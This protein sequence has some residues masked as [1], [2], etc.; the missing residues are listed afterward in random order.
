MCSAHRLAVAAGVLCRRRIVPSSLRF[1]LVMLSALVASRA[2]LGASGSNT[3]YSG[4]TSGSWPVDSSWGSGILNII[5]PGATSGTTN[6]DTATFDSGSI[7][8][9]IT[10]DANRNLENITFDTSAAAYTIGT[11]GGNA[12]LTTSFGTI[13]IASTFSGSNLNET[14]NAP[15]TLEGDYTLADNSAHTGV[16]LDFGGAISA[17]DK[18]GGGSVLTVAGA[19]NTAI[20][21]AIGGIKTID[22]VKSG[23]G[24]LTLSGNNTFTGGVTINAGTLQVDSAGAL[25]STSPDAVAF[26]PGSTGSLILNVPAITI[27]GLTT[28]ATPGSPVVETFL[29]TSAQLTINNASNNNY[30]GALKDS[31]SRQF[32]MGGELLSLVKSGAGTLTLSGN[33]A[34]LGGVTINAGNLAI[35]NP[36]ALN[37]GFPAEPNSVMFGPGSTG[38]LSLNGYSIE[39]QNLG[40][41]GSVGSPVIQN[42]S[43]NAA[44]LTVLGQGRYAGVLRDG[45]GGG[46]LA[47]AV[48][49]GLNLGGNNAFTGGLTIITPAQVF[50]ANAGALN[51]STPNPVTFAPNPVTFT[52][53]GSLVLDGNSVTISGLS[54]G[55]AAYCSIQSGNFPATITINM[56]ANSSS[57]YGGRLVDGGGAA[58]SLVKSGAGMLTLG[59]LSSYT[60]STSVA[61]GSLRGGAANAFSSVSALTVA[62]GATFDLGGFAQSIGSLAGA[63][64][65]T[66]EGATGSDMLTVGNDDTST[67]FAGL[68]SNA[69]GG[70]T[71]AVT[72]LGAGTLVLGGANTFTGGVTI[73]AGTLQLAN[74]G[75]LNS[76]TP[77][78]VTF[79]SGS[80]GTLSLNGNSVTVPGLNTIATIGSPVI[81]NANAIAATLTVNNAGSDTYAGVLQDGSAGGA[82]ALVKNGAGTLTLGGNNG[83]TGGVTINAGTLQLVNPGALNSSNPN[84]VTF[85]PASTGI[86]SLNGNSSVVAGLNTNA[87]LGSP[88]VENASATPATLTFNIAAN[89]S[90][91][92][93][94]LQ[95]GPGGGALSLTKTGAGTLT[96]SGTNSLAGATTVMAGTLTTAGSGTIGT[97]PLTISTA[98]GVASAVNLGSSQTVS[99]LSGTLAGS[100][101]T[102]SIA[103]GATLTDNQ[104]SGSTAF[105]GLLINSGEFIKSGNSSLEINGAPTLNAN[106]LLQVNGGTL[107]FNIF[108]GGAATVGAGVTATVST[109]ATLELANS[110]SALSSGANRVNIINSSNSPGL[111]VSGTNQ[112]VG[113]IDGGGT[114]QVN[115]GKDLTANHIVQSALLI[116]GTSGSPALVT[117]DASDASGNPLGQSSGFVSASSLTPSDPFGAGSIGSAPLSSS[118][119][120]D[121]AAQSAGNPAA[122]GN[123]APVPEPS[124]L[125]LALLAV[126]SVVSTQFAR[127]HL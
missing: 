67:S 107:R 72:K 53:E 46:A 87:T 38:T 117:I 81:Q 119:N 127:H 27:G 68:I 54:S 64:T 20:S 37:S 88:V 22:L 109:G 41:S 114:T 30:A 79:G 9:A 13:Q 80:T 32:G 33:N 35:G 44:T 115:A 23:A 96:L 26:G 112:R 63:G 101:P 106:S 51:S 77:N 122:G 120:S 15:L 34:F 89:T 73:N 65:V 7:V 108:I 86:L 126:L 25:N 47:L 55:P 5:V 17:A 99:S 49:G 84:T 12:L 75:A 69:S 1:S 21:G 102:L 76:S 14:I 103:G 56:A 60:G 100:V 10:P 19:G 85:G 92:P 123:S 70:R 83:F 94:V 59:Y 118:D 39:I 105:P 111:L 48:A 93:G 58:L 62:N 82:L 45:P 97:G 125:P 71:L 3:W 90:T 116:G 2:A 61:A 4:A 24:T 66:T 28:N 18:P 6:A 57:T 113:N 43:A 124:T 16:S 110:V 42:A 40:T 95:D 52:N 31:T 121:L 78:S 50:L 74:P 98:N 104:S 36:G 11:T 91:Y 29:G 8:T